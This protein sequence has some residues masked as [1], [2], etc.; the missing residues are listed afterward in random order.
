MSN[1]IE[2]EKEFTGEDFLAAIAT[3]KG[4]A[5]GISFSLSFKEE[6]AIKNYVLSGNE[7]FETAYG[8]LKTMVDYLA[9]M[10]HMV[11]CLSKELGHGL[12][13]FDNS[14]EQEAVRDTIRTKDAYLERAQAS[15]DIADDFGDVA[16]DLC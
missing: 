6:N 2:E 11:S 9:M 12:R 5:S 14:A 13:D 7:D 16:M 15:A 1:A 10:D 8:L 3:V 4:K